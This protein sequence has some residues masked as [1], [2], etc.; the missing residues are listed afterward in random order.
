MNTQTQNSVL[1]QR[2]Y[3]GMAA[4]Q[5]RAA[6]SQRGRETS[7]GQGTAQPRA[8]GLNPTAYLL[9]SKRRQRCPGRGRRTRHPA[10]EQ[11]WAAN[12]PPALYQP[13]WKRVGCCWRRKDA[14]IKSFRWIIFSSPLEFQ[15]RKGYSD[16]LNPENLYKVN[17]D[18]S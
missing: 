9:E 5:R 2:I 13:D 17:T 15:H 4:M 1:R 6:P 3:L 7:H 8:G 11:D 14:I 16:F 10:P 12:V 18:A